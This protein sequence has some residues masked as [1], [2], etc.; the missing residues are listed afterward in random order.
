MRILICMLAL[1][2][3]C[4]FS[5]VKSIN[6]KHRIQDLY[7]M[8]DDYSVQG[9]EVLVKT[10]TYKK[11]YRVKNNAMKVPSQEFNKMQALAQRVFRTKASDAENAQGSS[12]YVGGRLLLTNFHVYS[13]NY[14]ENRSCGSFAIITNSSL[15]KVTLS[16]EKVLRCNK[17][18]DYCLVRMK[19]K[20]KKKLFSG[21]VIKRWSLTQLEPLKFSRA[22]DIGPDVVTRVIGN[23]Q[24]SGIH[25]SKGKGL[26]PYMKTKLRFYAPVFQGNSG[27]PLMNE[28]GEVVGVVRS[29]T[30]VLHGKDAHNFG[31]P[32]EKIWDDLVANVSKEVLS[33]INY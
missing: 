25:T 5:G 17:E 7:H 3:F 24:F 23:P 4:A 11:G 2:S 10:L 19:D 30:E 6:P 32:M 8:F 20:V 1:V 15:D 12:F 33:K 22:V 14:R 18:L 9:T 27:G 28:A 16:C 29:Q 26:Y 13:P 21:K 31:I